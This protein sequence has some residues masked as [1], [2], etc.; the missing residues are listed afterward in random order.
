M[1]LIKTIYYLC[2]IMPATSSPQDHA[3]ESLCH[4]GAEDG[5]G[6]SIMQSHRQIN[7]STAKV[8]VLWRGTKRQCRQHQSLDRILLGCLFCG[9]YH[10][11]F[12]KPGIKIDG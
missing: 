10:Q 5:F 9:G 6:Q 11:A 8:A 3:L 4:Q 1:R 2:Q 12:R 7:K